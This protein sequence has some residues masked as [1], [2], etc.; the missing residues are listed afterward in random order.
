MA[1]AFSIFNCKVN[2]YLDDGSGSPKGN[3]L[4]ELKMMNAIGTSTKTALDFIP[5]AGYVNEEIS[6]GNTR[7]TLQIEKA[8]ESK[9]RDLVLTDA[10]YYIR[11]EVWNDSRSEWSYYNC[12]KCRRESNNLSHAVP[13]L[14][15]ATFLCEQ[16]VSVN[17]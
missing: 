8:V 11:I 4:F 10:L 14:A 2:I 16:I 17:V 9:D 1:G 7:Y 5:H 3:A 12:K 6:A 15:Q 13:S